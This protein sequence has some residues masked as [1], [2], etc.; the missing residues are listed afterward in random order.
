[1]AEEL[2]L[3]PDSR[4]PIPFDAADPAFLDACFRHLLHPLEEDGVDFWWLDWQ[5]GTCSS[6]PGLDPLPLL[7]H[8]FFLDRGRDGKLPF[9]FSRYGG[10]GSHRYPIGFS[11]DSISTWDS[12]EFQP[13]FTA[14]ASNVGFSWWSNDIGGHMLG[15]RDDER[16]VR[17]V[18]FGT[19]SPILR[20]HSTRSPFYGKEPWNCSPEA[21]AVMKDFLRLRHALIPYLHTMNWRTGEEGIPLMEPMY[22]RNDVPEAYEVPNQY[23]FGSSLI[24]CPITRP[25]DSGTLLAPFTGWLPP[26]YFVDLFTGRIYR[27]DRTMTF[28]RPLEQIPVLLPAG[29]ILPLDGKCMDSHLRNPE[30][31]ILCVAHGADGSF[32][33]TEDDCSDRRDSPVQRTAFTYTVGERSVRFSMSTTWTGSPVAPPD[34]TWKLRILGLPAPRK[35]TL[36]GGT[37]LS[38]SYEKETCACRVDLTGE[39]LTAFQ[40]EIDLDD[41]A[42]PRQDPGPEIFRLLQRAQ[43]SYLQKDRIWALVQKEREP[44]RLLAALEELDLQPSVLSALTE[45]IACAL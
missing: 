23:R 22:Y 45:Q 4:T 27:G 11:G 38:S 20:L 1:M 44:A 6:V 40:V 30:E 8:A 17:W 5:Q 25:R 2:G 39:D 9:T 14:N 32:V 13:C 43:I 18:Q 29:A 24:V 7:N 35:I 28:W 37:L 16:T 42:I 36:S 3:D 33:L 10:L 15:T 34:R 26:G 41:T 21:C 19:F 31:L 12:L